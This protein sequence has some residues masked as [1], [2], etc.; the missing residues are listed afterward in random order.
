[1]LVVI[2]TVLKFLAGTSI[3]EDDH[4]QW[5]STK[6]YNAGEVVIRQHYIYVANK[7]VPAGIAPEK[8]YLGDTAYW[9]LS[10]TSNLYACLDWY[11]YTQTKAPAEA[12]SMKFVVPWALGTTALAIFNVSGATSLHVEIVL[13]NGTTSYTRDIPLTEQSKSWW[14]YCFGP[15]VYRTNLTLSS[16]PPM[17]GTLTVLFTGSSLALGTLAVGT[18][19]GFG[20]RPNSSFGKTLDGASQRLVGYSTNEIDEQGILTLIKRPSAGRVDLDF[21][22]DQKD[23]NSV[24]DLI[25]RVE[26]VPALWI[27][28]NGLGVE[29]LN[30][31]GILQEKNSK[32]ENMRVRYT[33]GILGMV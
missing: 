33:V 21:L 19:Y 18:Q 4:P 17:S 26:S 16:L 23:S 28:D 6:T 13:D 1:M 24:E 30:V 31:F 3:A 29:M 11:R 2:P 5:V 14:D 8:S 10:G 15:T 25:Q 22:I 20:E 12:T 7:N 27:G 9:F 32:C